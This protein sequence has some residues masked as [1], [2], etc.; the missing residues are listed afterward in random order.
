MSKFEE[1]IKTVI[2]AFMDTFDKETVDKNLEIYLKLKLAYEEDEQKFLEAFDIALMDLDTLV[3][4][5]IGV[6][7][8]KNKYLVPYIVN[9]L[10]EH[11]FRKLMERKEGSAC[12]ADKAKF[13]VRMTLKALKGNTNLS[14]YTDYSNC[15]WVKEEKDRQACWSPKTVPDTNTAMKMFWDW[16]LV[17]N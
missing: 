16:Y 4:K 12:C 9:G 8:Q 11:Y 6:A 10:Y 15:D 5:V 2:E 17:K 3:G 7:D 1:N 14:L 13:I